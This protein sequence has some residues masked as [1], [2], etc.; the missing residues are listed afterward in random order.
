MTPSEFMREAARLAEENAGTPDGGPFGALL[1][2]D[3]EILARAVNTVVRDHDPTAHAEVNAIR[4]AARRLGTFDLSGSELYTSCEPCP[5]C[6][7]AIYWARIG[8]IYYGATATD[9]AAV[10]F[11]DAFIYH[12]LE[13]PR[14]EREIAMV[15]LE[16]ESCLK[17]FRAWEAN[18]EKTSY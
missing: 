9:A 8:K 14:E 18:E 3:G 16:R 15:E 6:L 12:E 2:R 10:G 4:E 7:A 11:A 13:R 1:V 17:A 5:M